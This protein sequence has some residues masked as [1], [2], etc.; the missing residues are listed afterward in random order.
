M[1]SVSRACLKRCVPRAARA[2]RAAYPPPL[3]HP[4]PTRPWSTA[5]STSTANGCPASS[6]YAEA[7]AKVRELRAEPARRRSS[8][9]GCTSPPST[10][11]RRSADVFGL[12]P[13]AVEDAVCAHQRPKLERYDESLFL[14]LKTV[15]Y[16]PHESIVLAREIVETGEIMVFVGNDFVVTVRHGEHGGLSDVRKRMDADPEQHAA[17]PVRGDARHR[18][19]RGGPLPRGEQSDGGR[20]RHHRGRGLRAG[21]PNSTSSRSTYSSARWSS[22]A[23]PSTRC[24]CRSQRM[25]TEHKDLIS[26]E[27]RR[28]LRDVGDHQTQAADQIASYDENAQLAGAGRAGPGRDAAEHRHAQDVGVGRPCWRYPR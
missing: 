2:R 14:V 5:A 3:P 10:R 1:P 9:S 7:C 13:L 19:L 28:Y 24:R 11:C 8:G 6:R 18:R 22:C 20:H 17:G 27:V 12:H 23:G 15:N 4:P 21:P 25:Q 16:V 26:K